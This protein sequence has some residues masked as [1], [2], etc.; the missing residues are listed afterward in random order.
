MLK[1]SRRT[2]G[3]SLAELLIALALIAILAV[4]VMS[5]F[6]HST[7]VNIQAAKASAAYATAQLKLEELVGLTQPEIMARLN[8][9]GFTDAGIFNITANTVWPFDGSENLMRVTIIVR[10]GTREIYRL[11]NVLNVTGV[12]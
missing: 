3:F 10:E 2:G 12:F 5:F 11:E 1:K 6:F 8:E 9:S 7:N 4:P